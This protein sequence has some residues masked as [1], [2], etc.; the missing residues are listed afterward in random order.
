[1]S[2]W[3]IIHA[4]SG[5]ENKVKEAILAEAERLGLSEGVEEIEV[6]TETVT[7]VK[8]GKKVQVERKFM[9]GYVLAKLRMNDDI[10]H[11]VKN[12]PKV[13]GFLGNNNKPQPISEREAAR[14]FGGVEEAKAAPKKDISVDYEIGD[15]VKVLDGPFASFNGVVEELD[16]DKAKVKVSVSIFGRATPVELDFE[17]VELVK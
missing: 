1:M 7:E 8:R 6:P 16:F 10:Y 14:Y 11:L 5:F 3:Y 4:Y 9:P 2:R 15:S 13:T 17:Q 12:T